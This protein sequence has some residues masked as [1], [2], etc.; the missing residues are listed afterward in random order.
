MIF[1]VVVGAIVAGALAIFDFLI[2]VA[3]R[4]GK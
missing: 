2:E 3:N 1:I 4:A